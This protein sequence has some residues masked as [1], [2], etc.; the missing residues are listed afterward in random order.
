MISRRCEWWAV[1]KLAA[2]C[3][4]TI[5][6]NIK[7]V[8]F[9]LLFNC[10]AN[11]RSLKFKKK[12]QEKYQFTR[13]FCIAMGTQK[14]RCQWIIKKKKLFLGT[15][16]IPAYIFCINVFFLFIKAVVGWPYTKAQLVDGSLLIPCSPKY[17]L[18]NYKQLQMSKKIINRFTPKY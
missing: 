14:K 1:Q 12:L 17:I 5:T 16:D 8:K 2:F 7:E 10:N 4:Y 11:Q 18:H 6:N 3:D 15:L 9:S 13:Q